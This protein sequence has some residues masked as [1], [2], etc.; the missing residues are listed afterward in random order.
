MRLVAPILPF[1]AEEIWK[2]LS[3]P[4]SMH[5]QNYYNLREDY[6]NPEIEENMEKV[7][8]IK[9]DALKALELIRKDGKI[10]ASLEAEL[11]IFIKD[12]KTREIC[13]GMGDEFKRFLQTAK[14]VL[15]D[16]RHSDMIDYDSS[17]INA[18]RTTGAKCVR[19][20][21]YYDD[22]G[23]DPEHPELC[24]RCTEVVKSL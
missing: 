17:S 20:W 12:E 16:E 21:N 10:K 3:K 23:S 14:A 6:N 1:T 2:F 11:F 15:A 22:L 5:T 18:Q 9:K 7:V 19:C 13:A 24:P 8:D 4:G